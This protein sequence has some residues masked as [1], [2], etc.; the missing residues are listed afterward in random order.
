MEWGQEIAGLRSEENRLIDDSDYAKRDIE[1]SFY[2]GLY[3]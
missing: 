1:E 2:R 3:M